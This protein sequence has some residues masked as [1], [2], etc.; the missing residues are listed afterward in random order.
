MLLVQNAEN[1]YKKNNEKEKTRTGA[2]QTMPRPVHRYP[3][4]ILEIIPVVLEETDPLF[5]DLPLWQ[6]AAQS[7]RTSI[8]LEY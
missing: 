1:Q 6:Q 7:T 3:R 4:F 5:A 8:A 2:M